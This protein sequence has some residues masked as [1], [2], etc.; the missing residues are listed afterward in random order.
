MDKIDH[1]LLTYVENN[2]DDEN[3]V[4]FIKENVLNADST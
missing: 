2:R 4:N 3:Y 1:D